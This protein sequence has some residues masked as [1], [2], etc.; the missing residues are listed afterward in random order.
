MA[1]ATRDLALI[2]GVIGSVIMLIAPLLV[3]LAY[4]Q[5]D[6]WPNDTTFWAATF[7]SP[8]PGWI[9][10][11]LLPITRRQRVLFAAPYALFCISIVAILMIAGSG[12]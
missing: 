8:L 9:G 2:R 1:A 12:I 11:L 10:L 5:V 6:R 3:T 7:A 4:D